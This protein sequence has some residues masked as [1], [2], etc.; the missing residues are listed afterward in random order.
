[1]PRKK[2]PTV[3]IVRANP[4]P[5]A[6]RGLTPAPGARLAPDAKLEGML[7]RLVQERVDEIMAQRGAVDLEPDFR[8]KEVAWE[9]Q[10]R[11]TVFERRKW[12]LYFSKWGCRRCD[13]KKAVHAGNGYCSKCH[14]LFFGR[15]T[16]LRREHDRNNPESEV[17]RHVEH[18]V[19]RVR[20]AERLLG[21]RG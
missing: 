1:M 13:R 3:E 7:T 5:P 19:S 15:L 4:A 6:P 11:Q 8:P 18:I 9:I 17:D 16:Q 12:S 20:N 2:R 14:G 10:R 21:S